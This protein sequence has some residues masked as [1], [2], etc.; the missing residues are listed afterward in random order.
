MSGIKQYFVNLKTFPSIFNIWIQKLVA[1]L[2][3]WPH[4]PSYDL[5]VFP[6]RDG[7]G[8][9]YEDYNFTLNDRAKKILHSFKFYRYQSL[10]DKKQRDGHIQPFMVTTTRGNRVFCVKLDHK[11]HIRREDEYTD[12]YVIRFF[13][14]CA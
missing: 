3:F 4:K 12:P 11:T 1:L 8:H 5:I 6:K 7:G 13:K 9:Y 2:A 10:L 14:T